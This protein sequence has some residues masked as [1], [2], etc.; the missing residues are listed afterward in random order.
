MG[1][2][3]RRRAAACDAS[4]S[5]HFAIGS[6]RR[7]VEW[8]TAVARLLGVS[9]SDAL[10][11]PCCQVIGGKNDFGRAVCGPTCPASKTLDTGSVT[12]TARMLAQAAGG[13]RLRLA[14]DLVALPAGGALARL[15]AADDTSPDLT[16]DLAGVAA[17][18]TRVSGE[19]LQQGLG[20]ALD[21]LL[22]ATTAD[23]GEAFLAAPHGGGAVRT[24]HRGRFE[25]A[26]DEVLRFDPGE[27]YPGLVLS[28]GQPVYT[29]H[30]AEDPRF[31]RVHVKREGFNTYVCTPMAN[32]G[33]ALGCLALAFR[34]SDIDLK[35]VLNLLCWVGTPMGLVVETALA[36]LRDAATVPL[37]G[38]EGDPEHRLPRALHALLREMVR[39]GRA[40]GGELFLPWQGADLRV[41]VPNAGAVPR[42]PALCTAALEQ[43]PSFQSGTTSILH[44]RRKSW[45]SACRDA[46]HPG[47][48]WCCV[49]M[50]CDGQT[51]GMIR[52]R[53]RHLRPSPPNE[54]LAL[55][56][57]L[58]SLAAEKLR[59]LR[60][61]L[62]QAGHPDVARGER[63][64]HEAGAREGTGSA[65]AADIDEQRSEA[66][67]EIRCLGA[68][69]LSVDGAKVTAAAICR[70]RVLT[71]LG[72]LLTYHDQPQCKDALIEML[73]PGADPDVRTRQLHVLVHELRKLIEPGSHAGG[74]LYVR[75][76][77]DRYA[78]NT[79]SACWLDTAQFRAL[80]DLGRKAE[81]ARDEQAAIGAYEAATELYRG[82][83][84][85][86]EPFAEWC[87]QTREQLREACLGALNRLA[88]LWGGQRRWDKSIACSR[89]ALLVD[90]LRE[91]M[92]RSLMY[93]LWASGRRDEAVRQY[94]ACAHLLRER[95]DLAPLPETDQ[96]FARIRATP[97]PHRDR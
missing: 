90:P 61:Q 94:E 72:I 86:D 22:H 95:L 77:A 38:V 32:H 52:L 76:Q 17:L 47:G 66:R 46:V 55:I 81:A 93:A 1:R 62:T 60:D 57:G 51:L 3:N 12:G 58:A 80:L 82:D 91:E 7:I 70:K 74:W 2:A 6:D 64:R 11:L 13:A 65:T 85:Q 31:L 36:H 16:H 30:L 73:W 39:V 53:Y 69:E 97:R 20:H 71:L 15:R 21:F 29:D 4:A 9:G 67:L 14:C 50:S 56:E 54:N 78:F 5:G 18:T 45:P 68:L 37:H 63:P 89:R 41:S 84:L 25:R 26:F 40:D 10:G 23:A 19:R 92:H 87:W 28:H 24:C 75:S 27:G 34:R 96:L 79:Q 8:D 42:C 83:Y 43:C 35:R 59:D 88:T 49:S 48:A 44:G 33:T